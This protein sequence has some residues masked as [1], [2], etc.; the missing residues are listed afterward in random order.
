MVFFENAL[1]L[2]DLS[3]E[4]RKGE[5]VGRVKDTMVAGNAYDAL[6]NILALSK[7]T[8]WIEGNL[9]T[10]YICIPELTVVSK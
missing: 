2:N 7:E 6:S 10:P 8:E 3:L 4:V 5:I 9:N 1:A